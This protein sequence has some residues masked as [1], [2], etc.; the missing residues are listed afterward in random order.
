[1]APTRLPAPRRRP[2]RRDPRMTHPRRLKIL[3]LAAAL[4]LLAW[5]ASDAAEPTF[6]NDVEP[7]IKSYCAECHNGRKKKGDLNL[8]RFPSAT[9]AARERDLWAKVAERVKAKEMPPP[10]ARRQPPDDQRAVFAGWADK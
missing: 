8:T 2:A 9:K 3:C 4:G 10:D 5:S 7:F 6:E 1:M